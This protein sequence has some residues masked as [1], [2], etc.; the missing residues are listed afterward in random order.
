MQITKWNMSDWIA[1]ADMPLSEGMHVLQIE[2]A[3]MD[4][5]THAYTVKLRCVES[6]EVST[7]KYF[8]VKKDGSRNNYAV[9][10]LNSLGRALFGQDV[11]IPF[12]NDIINGVV[13]AEVTYNGEYVKT[14]GSK[15]KY[16]NIYSYQPITKEMLESLR[17][18]GFKLIDQYTEG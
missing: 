8:P 9:G 5:Q 12:M 11:G 15:G 7:I 13:K 3:E 18:A 16:V 17:L 1:K 4:D 10:S 14:D 6:D 2:N